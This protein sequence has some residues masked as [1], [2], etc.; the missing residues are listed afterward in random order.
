MLRRDF[1]WNEQDTAN[2]KTSGVEL[3]AKGLECFK[4][5]IPDGGDPS[6]DDYNPC[7]IQCMGA[8]T[9]SLELWSLV[10]FAAVGLYVFTR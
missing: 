3:N 8:P 6:T 7:L 9:S 1:G 2:L 10:A 5:C 4:R